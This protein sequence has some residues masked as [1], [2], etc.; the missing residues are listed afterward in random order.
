MYEIYLLFKIAEYTEDFTKNLAVIY[1]NWIHIIIFRLKADVVFF[2]IEG[3]DRGG[4]IHQS[5]NQITISGSITLLY[6][7]LISI[8]NSHINHRI[9]F[10]L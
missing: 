5:Y 8:K 6:K 7:N 2:F 4:I 1:N 9:T 3:F 10:Y